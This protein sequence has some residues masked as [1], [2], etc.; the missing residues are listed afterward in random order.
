MNLRPQTWLVRLWHRIVFRWRR[1]QLA[2][3]LAE[4]LE[5][6]FEQ[7]RAE[8]VRAGIEPLSAAELPRRQMG[9]ITIAT[10]ECRDMWSFMKWERLVQDLRHP[11]PAYEP[12][13]G[14]TGLAI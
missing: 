8:N 2:D 4:E 13:P 9:N 3:E 1:G 14:F 6:H 11:L 5:F 12:Q 10:E 7:K